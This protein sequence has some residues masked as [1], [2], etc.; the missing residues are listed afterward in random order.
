M[1]VEH[2]RTA[3]DCVTRLLRAKR[4]TTPQ[5]EPF[6]APGFVESSFTN[7]YPPNRTL[8]CRLNSKTLQNGLAQARRIVHL[9]SK[10][11]LARFSN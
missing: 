1:L 6:S 2:T 5:E 4:A 10:N 7:Q 3:L 8:A 9:L 11:G